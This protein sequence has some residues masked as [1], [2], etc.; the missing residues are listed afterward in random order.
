[1][2]SALAKFNARDD[3]RSKS[4]MGLAWGTGEGARNYH[5]LQTRLHDRHPASLARVLIVSRTFLKNQRPAKK[6]K[7]VVVDHGGGFG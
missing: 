6:E 1:M 5:P 4:F 3:L 7:G 2:E